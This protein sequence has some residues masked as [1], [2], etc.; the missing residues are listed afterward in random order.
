M[1]IVEEKIDVKGG[2]DLSSL[3]Q[4]LNIYPAAASS[5]NTLGG[6]SIGNTVTTNNIT[7]PIFLVFNYSPYNSS[8]RGRFSP[9]FRQ[10]RKSS[11]R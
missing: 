5:I 8:S 9:Y 2:F 4:S 10:S 6:H 3:L 7:M 1:E 11:R